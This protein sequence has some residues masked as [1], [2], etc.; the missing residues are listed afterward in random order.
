VE[1][2]LSR[3]TAVAGA[4]LEAGAVTL[5]PD[6]PVTF[7]SGLVSPVYVDSR[8]LI[9]H[10]GPWHVVVD[11][12][13]TTLAAR[14]ST[15]TEVIAGV[16][17][18]GIPHSSALAYATDRPSVFV[19][20]TAK[21]HGLGRRIEGG[22]VNGRRVVL[23]EDMV[24]TGGSSLSAISA[25]RDAGAVVDV[26]LAIITYGFAG[27]LEAFEVAGVELV[28]MTTFDAVVAESERVGGMGRREAGIVHAWLADPQGWAAA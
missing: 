1:A 7:R 8:Q 5:T 11:A 13:A 14:P 19:R 12:F 20:K 26:C 4:L 25:L 24:T 27:T 2:D 6:E 22:G 16:E 10:P 15:E 21:E 18:A 28:V 23:V 9:S 17:A 3:D